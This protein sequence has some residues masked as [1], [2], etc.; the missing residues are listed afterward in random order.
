MLFLESEQITEDIADRSGFAHVY[1]APKGASDEEALE[2]VAWV[3]KQAYHAVFF[4]QLG[5]HF[6]DIVLANS[7]LAR[8]QARGVSPHA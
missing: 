5:M 2:L 3:R 6:A 1:V 4:P 7:R 8:V